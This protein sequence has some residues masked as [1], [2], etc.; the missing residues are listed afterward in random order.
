MGEDL[1]R[2]FVIDTNILVDYPGIVPDDDGKLVKPENPSIS[3]AN[4]NIVI[5]TAVIRELSSFKEERSE[6]GKAARIVL[7]RIRAM[8]ET[9]SPDMW[10]SYNLGP[11][12]GYYIDGSA[13]YIFP[14]HA[15]FKELL[16]FRPADDDMD[17]QII[18]ATIA[19]AMLRSGMSIEDS[20]NWTKRKRFSDIVLKGVTLLT[21]DNGLAIRARERGISTAR[22]GQRYHEPYTGRRK[23]A[24]PTE[25]MREFLNARVLD[26]DLWEDFLPNEPKLVA[27]EFVEMVLSEADSDADDYEY[28]EYAVSDLKYFENVGRYDKASDQIVA[29]KYASKFKV[30]PR[31][32]GQA[33]YAEALMNKDF[34]AVICTG[35]AGAGKTFMATVYGF[36]ATLDGDYIGVTVVPCET[37]GKLGAL[38]GGMNEKL[39]PDVQPFKNALRNY[40]L[41][42]D[43]DF[44][45]KFSEHKREGMRK[46]LRDLRNSDLDEERPESLRTKLNRRVNFYWDEIF[47]NIP[48]DKARGRDFSYEL[49]LYDEFQD[50]NI[51]QA[52]TLIKRLGK[53]GRIVITGDVWQIHSPYLDISNNG[54][55]YASSLLYDNPYVAQVCFTEDEVVRHPLV[56][57]IAKKQKRETPKLPSEKSS[58]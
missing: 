20:A 4:S 10:D 36:N 8:T 27:N 6:R 38:P 54:L 16:P 46:Y 23:V 30:A 58:N 44:R 42:E 37:H 12:A 14:V 11:L 7:R 40:L 49:A 50:Q 48:I 21:N 47:T 18:L 41:S 2:T 57:E 51:T 3:L 22:Y 15:E 5:P 53:D 13:F 45:Q 25:I 35:P 19:V 39:D 31:N 33:I 17:G 34:A 29:L 9:T 24:V 32:V 52:D 43:K 55:V 1:R 56:A 26:R 28:L